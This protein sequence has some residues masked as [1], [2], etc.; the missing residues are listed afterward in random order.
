MHTC[1]RLRVPRGEGGTPYAGVA[2]G[3]PM[4]R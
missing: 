1:V 3:G 2:R 4:L